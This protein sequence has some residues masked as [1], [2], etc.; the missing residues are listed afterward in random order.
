MIISR[1]PGGKGEGAFTPF[2][3]TGN[4]QAIAKQ[5][6]SYEIRLLSSGK[7]KMSLDMPCDIFLVG[8]G[9]GG[10]RGQTEGQYAEL[11]GG[12]GGGGGYT[13]TETEQTLYA[14]REY[15][16]VIGAGGKATSGTSGNPTNG[17]SSGI[18]ADDSSLSLSVSGGKG[19]RNGQR[20]AGNGGSGGG[21]GAAFDSTN[22]EAGASNG[23]T[24]GE[25]VTAESQGTTTRAFGEEGGALYAG[26][27]GGS[28]CI[29][30]VQ[31]PLTN[32]T[33]GKAGGSGGGGK[34]GTWGEAGKNGT[35]NTGGGGG[36]SYN[37]QAG[38][39]GSGIVIIRRIVA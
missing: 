7:L 1:L 34:G 6:G 13:L 20:T 33:P 15:S 36:G 30:S 12:G 2:T 9:G 5:N 10:G 26:G 25:Q 31:D 14:I 3:Y 8:G 22:N 23:E 39:G 35:A 21:R 4:F 27:G 32:K 16:V 19:A 29:T 38:D 17:G 18:F 37:L 11:C 24:D 28:G